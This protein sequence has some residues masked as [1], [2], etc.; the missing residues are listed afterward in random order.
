ITD[1]AGHRHGHT[2]YGALGDARTTTETD[3]DTRGASTHQVQGGGVG[4]ATAD[5][6]RHIEVVDELLEVERFGT[7]GDVFGRDRGAPDHEDVHTG[8]DD[9]PVVLCCVV[10]G[11]PC[12]RD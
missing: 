8:V 10:R 2:Q 1:G 11:Q 9:R 7:A 12:V 3:Q 5:H 6:H 4:G